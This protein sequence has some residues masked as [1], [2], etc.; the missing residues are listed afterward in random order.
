MRARTFDEVPRPPPRTR[1]P[2]E[3]D[4]D[5]ARPA[6]TL[7]LALGTASAQDTVRI[8]TEGAYAPWN[9]LDD[10][11]ELAGFEI[12]LGNARCASAPGITCE[13]VQNEWDSIIPNLQAGNYDVI[14]AGMS[15]TEERM[16]HD[17]VQRADYYPPDPSRYIAAAG[18]RDRLRR[19][20]AA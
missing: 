14:M 3:Q 12:D 6:A 10:A 17:R 18:H 11:G 13:F 16:E 1:N 19:H 7:A 9:Y 20:E 2:N 5:P 4:P 8:G 15:I